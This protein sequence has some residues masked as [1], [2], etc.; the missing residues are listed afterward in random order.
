[1]PLFRD[2]HEVFELREAHD[3][4]S[5]PR[6]ASLALDSGRDRNGIGRALAARVTVSR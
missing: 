3:V 1:V 4:H 5:I 2:R 6:A